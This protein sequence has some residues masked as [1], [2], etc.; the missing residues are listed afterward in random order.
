MI[1][2]EPSDLTSYHTVGDLAL[3]DS[4]ETSRGPFHFLGVAISVPIKEKRNSMASRVLGTELPVAV[5]IL[6]D[7]TQNV[8]CTLSGFSNNAKPL[9]RELRAHLRT[10]NFIIIWRHIECVEKRKP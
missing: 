9:T 7:R 2:S 10:I 3:D 1:V 6:P 4:R 5:V 8:L